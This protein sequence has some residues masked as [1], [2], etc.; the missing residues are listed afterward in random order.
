M[1]GVMKTCRRACWAIAFLGLLAGVAT[2]QNPGA[3]W[4]RYQTPEDAG[5]SPEKLRTAKEAYDSMDAAAFLV[6]YDGKVLV[7]W[8]DV[9]RRYMCHSVRKSFLSALYGTHVDDGSIDIDDTLA[10]LGID[11]K[12]TLSEGEKQASLRDM[13]KARSGVYHPAAYETPQMKR[14]RPGRGSHEPG[15]FWYYNNWDFNTLC[16]VLEEQT[17]TDIF[18]DFGRRIA[19]PIAME[20][21]RL[22][23]GYHHYEPESMHPAYPFKMSARDMARFGLLFLRGG[24][25]NGDQVISEAWIEEST[26]PYSEVSENVGYAYM[27]WTR[28]SERWGRVYTARG[29]GGH[30]IGVV[31]GE[32]VV[33]VQRVDTYAG[34]SVGG[35][36]TATLLDLILDARVSEPSPDS[37]LGDFLP[38]VAEYASAWPEGVDPDLYVREYPTR[39][40]RLAIERLGDDLLLTSSDFGNYRVFAITEFK[41]FVEDM[42]QF[43]VIEFDGRE[44]VGLTVHHTSAVADLYSSLVGEGLDSALMLYRDLE[45]A[46]PESRL[47][48]EAALNSL[49]Y[50]LLGTDR[51]TE[52]IAVFKL[53]VE[54]FPEAFN[55]Y[56]SLGE[57]YMISGDY[58]LATE[59]YRRSLELN[60]DNAN[61]E[62]M[63]KRIED[64]RPTD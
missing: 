52:A 8:G 44:P 35:N 56:D 18:E 16:T 46:D 47:F 34:R 63:L 9:T 28:D 27:W 61:A 2:G 20:D 32:D 19:E 41:F 13:L 31:P 29:Y 42:Q 50:Q 12:Q 5:W 38:P 64:Q 24:I 11:D 57:A 49:G 60:P 36:E 37:D 45:D 14:L 53:N 25:W 30:I 58:R 1:E 7:S 59:N 4:Q 23:D 40:S 62:Q 17:G 54:V 55:T 15:T 26:T 10:E 33:Y 6:I 43:A 48:T 3:I 22:I 51:V 39:G 21:F